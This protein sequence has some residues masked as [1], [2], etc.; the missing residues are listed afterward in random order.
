MPYLQ[1]DTI[2]AVSYDE[3]AHLLKIRFRADGHVMIYEDVPQEIY[4]SLIFADSITG[5]FEA[6]IAG[7]YRGRNQCLDRRMAAEW[8]AKAAL[9]CRSPSTLN[10]AR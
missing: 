6:H 8:P 10:R 5:F 9:P 3:A 1:S 2:E 4:D 7:I